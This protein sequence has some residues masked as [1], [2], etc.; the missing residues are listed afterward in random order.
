MRIGVD[1]M[2]SGSS[3]L[4]LFQAVIDVAD[5]LSP[6]DC[7]VVFVGDELVDTAH[8]VSRTVGEE[9]AAIEVVG[10]S[11]VITMEEAPLSAI[12]GKRNSSMMEGIRWLREHRL[13][14]FVS[15]GNTGAL[16]AAATLLLPRLPGID[17]AALLALLPTATGSVVVLDVGGNVSVKAIHL[18][19]FALMGAAYQQCAGEVRRPSVG[20]LNIGVESLKGTTDVREAYLTLQRLGGGDDERAPM[21]FCGNVEGREV[22]QGKVQVLVTDGFTGNI[23][24]KTAEG[25]SAFLLDYVRSA[26]VREAGS[27]TAVLG[28]LERHINYEEYPGAIVCGVEGVVVKCHGESSA[29][30]MLNSIR[31]AINLVRQGLLSR[32]KTRIATYPNVSST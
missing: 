27:V 18:V 20:L 24:L 9:A 1:V 19:Q 28:E 6:S 4:E 29:H 30:G 13:E 22:F 12:R 5:E 11:Q 10:V 3:P 14:A 26:L 31:G 32:I 15:A 7:L 8:E 17:R 2:G 25:V 21:K 16:V 23:F